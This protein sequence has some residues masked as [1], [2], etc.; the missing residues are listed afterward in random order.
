MDA[1]NIYSPQYKSL[2]LCMNFEQSRQEQ[3]LSHFWPF[4]KL[5]DERSLGFRQSDRTIAI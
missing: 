1:L 5:F 2:K 4:G 3:K